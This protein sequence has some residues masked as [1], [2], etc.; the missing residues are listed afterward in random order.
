MMIFPANNVGT[1]IGWLAGKTGKVG[2]LFSP[3]AQRDP[4]RLPFALD[5]GRFIS[6]A[7]NKPWSEATWRKLLWF[8]ECQ[9]QPPLWVL[10]PDVVLNAKKTREEWDRYAP[11]LSQRFTLA[12]AVQDGSVP[13]DVPGEAAVVFVGGSTEWKWQTVRLW[14]EIFPRVHVGRVN[15]PSRLPELEAMGVESCDGT[16][17]FRGGGKSKQAIG[18]ERYLLGENA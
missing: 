6:W 3:G 11:E 18:L 1:R 15:S 7:N 4:Y 9:R 16:G 8:A 10:V 12:Y 13:E 14:A 5:N 17:W 2:L